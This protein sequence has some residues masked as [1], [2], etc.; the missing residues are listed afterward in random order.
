MLNIKLVGVQAVLHQSASP[1]AGVLFIPESEL[2]RSQAKNTSSN[3]LEPPSPS[4][5]L[6]A[7]GRV[8]KY[9][10]LEDQIGW[11]AKALDVLQ[12]YLPPS[13]PIYIIGHSVGAYI[14][15]QVAQNRHDVRGI[16]LLFP[17]LSHIAKAPRATSLRYILTPTGAFLLHLFAKIFTYVPYALV[18]WLVALFTGMES[19]PARV[20]ASFITTRDAPWNALCMAIDEMHTIKA[21]P[22]PTLQYLDKHNT[23]VRTYWGEGDSVCQRS[24]AGYVGAF[25]A[26][27]T[28]GKNLIAFS[29][30]QSIGHSYIPDL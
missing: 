15:M 17:T 21:V 2:A 8:R 14:A 6:Q 3:M 18:C 27:K 28:C 30:M 20:T 7:L 19:Q 10:T 24:N 11:Q 4:G 23:I 29:G 13:S 1:K 16:Y 26:P 5:R 22:T 9:Y 12:S 25:L